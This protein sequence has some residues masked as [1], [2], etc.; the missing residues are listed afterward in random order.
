MCNPEL[1]LLLCWQDWGRA[2]D[3]RDLQIEWHVPSAEETAFVFYVLDL[4][5]QPELQRLQKC[6][7]GELDMSRS[8]S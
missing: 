6:A 7:Q 8:V 2:G 3:L 5:L 4:F 1:N